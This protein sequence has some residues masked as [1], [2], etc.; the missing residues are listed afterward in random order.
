MIA[1]DG[2]EDRGGTEGMGWRRRTEGV[3]FEPTGACALTGFQDQLLKPLGHPSRGEKITRRSGG[4]HPSRHSADAEPIMHSAPGAHKAAPRSAVGKVAT[5]TCARVP[6]DREAPMRRWRRAQIC[7]DRPL[8]RMGSASASF[9]PV[10]VPHQ[11]IDRHGPA[12][13]AALFLEYHR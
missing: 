11:I 2:G 1:E 12:P 8:C 4:V 13:A 9:P 7:A 5:P 3:G 6:S 10:E